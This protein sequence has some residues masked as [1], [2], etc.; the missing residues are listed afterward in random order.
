MFHPPQGAQ[1]HPW[2]DPGITTCDFSSKWSEGRRILPLLTDTIPGRGCQPKDFEAGQDLVGHNVPRL[3]P[4]NWRDTLSFPPASIKITMWYRKEIANR[5]W[6]REWENYCSCMNAASHTETEI[7]PSPCEWWELSNLC[8]IVNMTFHYI[9]AIVCPQANLQ[10]TTL[11]R[12][13]LWLK[14]YYSGG[15]GVVITTPGVV[16]RNC[17]IGVVFTV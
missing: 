11:S 17:K 9:P 15:V 1:T 5:Q 2:R 3:S 7:I 16:D 13:R 8:L 6:M 10:C 12:R 14:I 4:R